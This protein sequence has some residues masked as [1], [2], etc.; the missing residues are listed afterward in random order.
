M[1]KL[2]SSF[3]TCGSRLGSIQTKM[4]YHELLAIKSCFRKEVLVGARAAIV[5]H[6]RARVFSHGFLRQQGNPQISKQ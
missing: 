2:G 4:N 6:R 1:K 5:R 3:N